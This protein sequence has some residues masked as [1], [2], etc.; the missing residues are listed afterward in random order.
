MSKKQ[1][2]TMRS[3]HYYWLATRN[4]LGLFV[5]LVAST[6]GFC[7]FLTYGNPYVM[8]LIVD[9]ISADPVAPE[10][11]FD[12]F[13]SYIAALI[14]INVAG[15]AGQQAAGLRAVDRLQIAACTTTW[16]PWPST[17]LSN[18]SL[19]FHSNR[20][21]GTLVSQTTKFMSRLPRSCSTPCT[22]PFLPVLCS[23]AFTCAHLWRRRVPAYAAVLMAHARGVRGRQSYLHVQAHPAPERAGGERPEPAFRRA[24]RLGGQHLGGEDLRARG[25]RARPLRP[26]QPRGGGA[27]LEAH[28]GVAH[29]RHRDGVH[30]HRHHERG[31]RV[32]RGRQRVV[33]HHAGHARGDVHVHLH[34]DEPVQLHQ[35]RPAAHQPAPSATRAA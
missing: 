30:H 3:L 17:A 20:F 10:A 19:S 11:V 23:V 28:V 22:F 1:S 34:G 8:S 32:H 18:Q 27:R 31:G 35:H 5:A 2:L 4:H 29:A 16:P 7:G 15:Q 9:R 12:V 21:G 13:G 33:R 6:I 25:L 14:G 24:V 26:G